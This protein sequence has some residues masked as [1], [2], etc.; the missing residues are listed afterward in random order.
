MHVLFASALFLGTAAIACWIVARF[1]RIA[2]G[3]VIVRGAGTLAS[4]QLLGLIKVSSET[5]PKLYVSIFLLLLP[6][7]TLMWT[8]TVWLLQSLQEALGTMR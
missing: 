6:A 5:T 3:S 1:P 2:P 7:L 4:A 8:C